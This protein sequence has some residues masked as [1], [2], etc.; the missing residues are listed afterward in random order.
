MMNAT[1]ELRWLEADAAITSL[2]ERVDEAGIRRA[3]QALRAA[4][5]ESIDAEQPWQRELERIE[6]LIKG[7][8]IE[9]H[10]GRMRRAPP[11]PQP[12]SGVRRRGMTFEEGREHKKKRHKVLR[13]ERLRLQ[14][15]TSCGRARDL[16]GVTCS[17]CLRTDKAWR[18]TRAVREK[19]AQYL[20]ED[21]QPLVLRFTP[22]MLPVPGRRLECLREDECLTELI[23]ACGRQEAPGSSCPPN[24]ADRRDPARERD[25]ELMYLAMTREES[26]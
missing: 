18:K 9:L 12:G 22:R 25:G 10:R 21:C 15:C 1:P 17:R 16:G 3:Q 2:T 23:K 26:V 6:P 24:C 19:T 8:I 20:D 14:V 5:M 7:A 13:E 4:I 11:S